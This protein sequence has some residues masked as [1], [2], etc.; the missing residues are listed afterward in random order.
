MIALRDS[1]EQRHVTLGN[2]GVSQEFGEI[3][4]EATIH[5]YDIFG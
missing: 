1:E 2:D 5:L 4:T 3:W